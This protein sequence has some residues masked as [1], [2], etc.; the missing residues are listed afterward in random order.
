MD[1][2]PI[3]LSTSSKAAFI[4]GDITHIARAMRLSLQGDLAGPILPATY[5]RERLWKLLDN[6]SLTHPQLC[7]VDSLLLQLDQFEAQPPLAW[8][9]LAP[10]TAALFP[11]THEA[12]A[13]HRA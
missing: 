2:K 9:E 10:A 8:D 12:G 11:P 3:N 5:W 4:D 7:A 6:S 1:R 13:A